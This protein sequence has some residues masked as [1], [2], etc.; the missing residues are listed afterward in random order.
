LVPVW[1]AAGGGPP[2]PLPQALAHHHNAGPVQL[3]EV[4]ERAKRGHGDT[5]AGR[6]AAPPAEARRETQRRLAVI[7][8][9][10]GRGLADAAIYILILKR[11]F[12][13]IKISARKGRALK[14]KKNCSFKHS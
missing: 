10:V 13:Y 14:I 7:L 12:R 9:N 6:L 8:I 5:S 1:Q 3:A 2:P 4:A 11:G